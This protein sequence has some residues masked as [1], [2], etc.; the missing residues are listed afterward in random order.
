MSLF[1]RS[2]HVRA[3][4]LTTILST[5]PAWLS[6]GVGAALVLGSSIAHAADVTLENL[7]LI[8]K[9]S[10]FAIKR[11]DVTDSNLDKSEIAKLFMTETKP[12]EAAAIV[13]KLKASKFSIPEIQIMD[14]DGFKGTLRDFLAT[15]LNEG[16]VAKITVIGGLRWRQNRGRRDDS[17]VKVGSD[18]HGQCRPEQAAG[19]RQG[20]VET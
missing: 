19:C 14:K 7:N 12:E 10:T 1:H 17:T 11:V 2:K 16:K 18:G 20:Q 5:T 6:A 9:G 3:I 13:R 8:D 4:F 15:N